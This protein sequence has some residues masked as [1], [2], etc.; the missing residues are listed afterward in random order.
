MRKLAGDFFLHP[1]EGIPFF[2]LINF[3]F[4]GRRLELF[5]TVDGDGMMNRRYRGNDVLRYFT[6][7]VSKTLV[8]VD[9]IILL[10]VSLQII[11]SP[12]AESIRFG[13]PARTHGQKF[14]H[15]QRIHQGARVA[16]PKG[17]FDIIKIQAGKSMQTH[18]W[19]QMRIRR[20]RQHI[21]FMPQI[22]ECL[23]QIF[24]V[25]SLPATIGIAPVGQQ[26]NFQRL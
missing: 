23:T 7:P 21:D 4:A 18:R 16:H 24:D 20:S 13:K 3:P 12:D 17:M 1:D 8:I 15:I 14:V 22:T 9:D 25:Y 5:L 6:D 19:I 10:P 26:T 11:I 2:D